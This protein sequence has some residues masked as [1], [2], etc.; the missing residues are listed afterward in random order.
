MSRKRNPKFYDKRG[1]YLPPA[2]R[3]NRDAIRAGFVANRKMWL[4]EHP[5]R[6]AREFDMRKPDVSE[7]YAG[8]WLAHDDAMRAA[9][10]RDHPG[11][12]A[13]DYE[14]VQGCGATDQEAAEFR[15]W[16]LTQAEE[17]SQQI[18]APVP[19][20][21]YHALADVF[22]LIAGADFDGLVADI[23][24]HGVRE[25]IW[26]F[27][28]QVLDGRNRYRAAL[29]AGVE[30][31]TRTY[32]GADPVAFVISANLKRRH[33]NQ[34][35]RAMVADGLANLGEGR[36]D[37]TTA[38]ICAVSQEQAADMLNVSR[39]NV[40]YARQVRTDKGVADLVARGTINLHEARKLISL[41]DKHRNGAV[42]AVANKV[43]VRTAV[44]AAKKEDYNTK[45]AAAQP[46]ALEGTYR[47]FYAD[48]PWSLSTEHDHRDR[49]GPLRHFGRQADLAN[50]APATASEP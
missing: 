48:P 13:A 40:Q 6:K 32:D 25:P 9:Y 15:E 22:P 39:R 45:I 12:D 50:T 49:R 3:K 4:A 37:K 26:L 30:C 43:D 5:G 17:R 16:S 46:K 27:D 11:K 23:K 41:P 44:R 31:P 38:Q 2:E 7:W 35:Q 10:L 1:K 36:P 34:S 33:L 14:H 29:A 20:F 47:I 21:T 42:A 19:D 28:G 8:K 24:A 18:E